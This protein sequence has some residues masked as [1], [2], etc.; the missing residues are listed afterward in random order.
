MLICWLFTIFFKTLQI[1]KNFHE[2]GNLNIFI[3]ETAIQIFP[4]FSLLWV[5][6]NLQRLQTHLSRNPKLLPVNPKIRLLLLQ[7]L[8]RPKTHH[9]P[10]V[11]KSIFEVF[12]SFFFG[13]KLNFSTVQNICSSQI[14][15]FLS[16]QIMFLKKK[17]V[18]N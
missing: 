6:R 12:S 9:L 7:R 3:R 16:H 15:Q 5:I 10:Y 14:F 17:N 2:Q 13:G 8:K 18:I 1:R 4:V 11:S